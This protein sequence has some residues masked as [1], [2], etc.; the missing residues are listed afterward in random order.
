M[1]WKFFK[2]C[3]ALLFY[4]WVIMPFLTHLLLNEIML[5]MTSASHWGSIITKS[6]NPPKASSKCTNDPTSQRKRATS[7]N[8]SL[9]EVDLSKCD[10]L[11]LYGL[12]YLLMPQPSASC[13]RCCQV[14]QRRAEFTARCCSVTA[15]RG[16]VWLNSSSCTRSFSGSSCG[17]TNTLPA[18]MS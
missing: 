2:K 11:I 15:V 6:C 18:I 7:T 10:K 14:V 3:F 12:L 9:Q 5:F 8:S 1:R 16:T 13:T 17:S 4:L